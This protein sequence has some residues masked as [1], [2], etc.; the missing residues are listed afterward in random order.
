M[1]RIAETLPWLEDHWQALRRA[2]S[3]G[4]LPH[5]LLF[6]GPAGMGKRALAR[7]LVQS[8]LCQSPTGSSDACGHCA[9]CRHVEAGTHPDALELV[10]EEGKALIRVDQVREF[11]AG[12]G[13]S[14]ETPDGIRTA[15]VHPAEAMNVAAAN[16]LLK[17]LEEPAPGRI[18]ILVTER[19]GALL[20]T[21]RSR[22]QRLRFAPP[23]A[24]SILDWLVDRS[25]QPAEK[26]LPVLRLAGGAPLAALQALDDETLAERDGVFER[27]VD[28]ARG[29]EN[30]MALAADWMQADPVQR[31]GWMNG[32]LEDLVRL[33]LAPGS[34]VKNVDRQPILEK[35]A[36]HFPPDALLELRDRVLEAMRLS[37]TGVNLQL[38]L[39]NL[40]I[41]WSRMRGG[42]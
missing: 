25:G 17:T 18:I 24:E 31:L 19:A 22:C 21:I 33:A 10:P 35:M 20:P 7:H 23:A 13:L 27:W 28:L 36:R 12:L 34:E 1:S 26:V 29:R 9:A 42:S 32:W 4:R 40:L 41:D 30:P 2:R 14:S 11:C 39:E 15:L 6:E 8:L 5:A 38:L 16:S 3:E 37:S